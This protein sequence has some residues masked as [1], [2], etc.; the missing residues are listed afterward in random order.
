M[1]GGDGD[2]GDMTGGDVTTKQWKS[3]S[4]SKHNPLNM[5]STTFPLKHNI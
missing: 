2:S 1:I 4:A 3:F 5:L